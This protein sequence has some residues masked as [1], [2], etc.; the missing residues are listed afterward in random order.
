M[1]I[2]EIIVRVMLA[3]MILVCAL[4]GGLAVCILYPFVGLRP[5]KI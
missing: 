3:A 1:I 4:I 2:I 5:K